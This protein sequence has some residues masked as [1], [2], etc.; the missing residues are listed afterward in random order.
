[1][2]IL[3]L[4][5]HIDIGGISTYVL[6]LSKALRARG[7][8]VCCASGGGSLARRFQGDHI[9]HTALPIGPHSE[10]HPQLIEAYVRL[11]KLVQREDIKLIHAHTRLAQVL[12]QWIRWRLR[13]PFVTTC[14]GFLK[15]GLLKRLAPCWGDY[16][17][18]VSEP[19]REHLVNDFKLEKKRK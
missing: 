14:H 18:A 16:V 4:T 3:Q 6:A 8:R 11:A 19:V 5:P 17:I 12:A 13:V 9:S 7:F 10:L 1:M 2:N 15:K